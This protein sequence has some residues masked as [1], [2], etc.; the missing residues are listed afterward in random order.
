M[1]VK[2]ESVS[3]YAFVLLERCIFGI[4]SLAPLGIRRNEQENQFVHHDD[5]THN[6]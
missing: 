4:V 1:I 6:L 2:G 3:C 5:S